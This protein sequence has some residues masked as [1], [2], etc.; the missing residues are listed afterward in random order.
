[1]SLL[2][3]LWSPRDIEFSAVGLYGAV[4]SKGSAAEYDEFGNGGEFGIDS[5]WYGGFAELCAGGF[6]EV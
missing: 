5:L 4:G 3:L 2:P 6:A 1:M